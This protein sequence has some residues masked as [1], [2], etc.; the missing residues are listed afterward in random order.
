MLEVRVVLA[1]MWER[2]RLTI[3]K[4]VVDVAVS[5]A[6]SYIVTNFLSSGYYYPSLGCP[7]YI[8]STTFLVSIFTYPILAAEKPWEKCEAIVIVIDL[9]AHLVW[10]WLIS[11]RIARKWQ[12]PP[13]RIDNTWLP[14]TSYSFVFAILLSTDREYYF[15]FWS[16]SHIACEIYWYLLRSD[17]PVN[18]DSYQSAASGVPTDNDP[19]NTTVGYIYS[20]TIYMCPAWLI[21]QGGNLWQVINY[22]QVFVG[23][24]DPTITDDHLKNVFSQYGEIVHMKIPAGKRCGFVQFSEK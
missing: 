4:M 24:L 23:G 20:P 9:I 13:I 6:P 19:N 15:S 18:A 8:C 3:F 10:L 1:F 21:V 2:F 11:I 7:K 17:I 12:A 16:L 14:L 22:M 5:V